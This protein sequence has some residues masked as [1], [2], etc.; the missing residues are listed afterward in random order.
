MNKRQRHRGIKSF[1]SSST[2]ITTTGDTSFAANAYKNGGV[3]NV[4][5]TG[6]GSGTAVTR[7]GVARMSLGGNIAT[8]GGGS[9]VSMLA[10]GGT[11]TVNGPA[12]LADGSHTLNT[13]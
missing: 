10:V 9:G 3:V 13:L 5:T 12:A 7:T 11:S 6:A 1:D 2:T 4:T 8:R